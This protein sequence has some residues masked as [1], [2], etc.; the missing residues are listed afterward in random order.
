MENS[1]RVSGQEEEGKED[2]TGGEQSYREEENNSKDRS[3]VKSDIQRPSHMSRSGS[4]SRYNQSADKPDGL[5]GEVK[6]LLSKIF[7]FYTSFG[8]RIN[9]KNLRSN[10]FHKMMKDCGIPLAKTTLDLM[11]VSENHHK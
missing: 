11:F 10:K 8:E 2:G 9:L 7:Q 6:A 3:Q 5:A 4:K 1:R